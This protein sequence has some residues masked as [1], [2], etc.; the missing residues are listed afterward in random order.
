MELKKLLQ[1]TIF[2]LWKIEVG[3]DV[4]KKKSDHNIIPPLYSTK[5]PLTDI[6]KMLTDESDGIDFS[7]SYRVLEKTL[8]FDSVIICFGF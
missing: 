1:H 8:F 2:H 7:L 3:K 6:Q 5:H 4:T